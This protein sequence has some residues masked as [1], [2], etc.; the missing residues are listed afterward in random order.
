MENNCCGIKILDLA[1]KRTLTGEEYL[2]IA[3]KDHNYKTPVN[4]LVALIADNPN[5]KDIIEQ[6]IKDALKDFDSL[7]ATIEALTQQVTQL[8][9]QLTDLLSKYNNLQQ[10]VTNLTNNYG[11]LSGSLGDIDSLINADNIIS[12]VNTGIEQHKVKILDPVQTAI[13]SGQG[14]NQ[15]MPS[16]NDYKILLDTWTGTAEE[17]QALQDR[18]DGM[19]Y[20]IIDEE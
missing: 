18:V 19:T 15:P 8:Q 16:N 9:Q 1:D 14:I 6:A 10:A 11:D 12:I 2:A 4:Q 7:N 13:N 20:N 17:Y 5:L 3:E